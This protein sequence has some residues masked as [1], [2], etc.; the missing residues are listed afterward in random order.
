MRL[1]R[2]GNLLAMSLLAV[3][4]TAGCGTRV[5]DS[6][7][8][9][10][11]KAQMFSDPQTN[12]AN[13]QVAVKD[14][15]VTLSGSMPSDAARLEAYKIATNTLGVRKVNDQMTVQAPQQ[16]AQVTPPPAVSPQAAAPEAAAPAA[17]VETPPAKKSKAERAREA[18][19]ERLRRA[20][21]ERLRREREQRAQQEKAESSAQ[22][23]LQGDA[24]PAQAVNPPPA[25][26]SSQAARVQPANPP[27]DAPAQA[28]APAPAPEPPPPPQPVSAVFPA[29]TTVEIQ[30][31]D[32]IDS[33]KAQPGDEYQAT[34]AQPLTWNGRVVVPAGA[35][36]YLRLVAAQESGQ[37]KGRSELQLQLARLEFQGAQYQMNS[38]TYTVAGASRG[39]N[40]A[41]KVGGGAILGAII[42][43]I[44]GGGKG[45]VIGGA[46]G[47][48]A[49]GVVQ[50]VTK[51]KQVRIPSETKLDF[52]LEKTL[53]IPVSPE[54]AAQ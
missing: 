52:Q 9:T 34:L 40:T 3:A 30:T 29:G 35:N 16:S 50:G 33:T 48:G 28:A 17:P 1:R 22:V 21:A 8:S 15:V 19:Q 13:L 23:S 41:E 45:A 14:G 12:G 5:S 39:K 6:Q 54:G 10:N 2:E 46:A 20:R 26:A 11:L 31:V 18:K 47:A 53:K 38:S 43:A 51:A 24:A 25:N 49:G 4:L 37:Y 32:P 42:G 44:A 7:L 36:V 27:A